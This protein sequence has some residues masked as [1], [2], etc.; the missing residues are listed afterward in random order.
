[1]RTIAIESRKGVIKWPNL[2]IA[3]GDAFRLLLQTSD[4]I[5]VWDLGDP[6]WSSTLTNGSGGM[7]KIVNAEFGPSKHELVLIHDFG[8]KVT[9]WS[10]VSGRSVEI[11]DPKT[12]VWSYEFRPNSGHLAFLS[13]PAA[14]DILTVHNT[15]SYSVMK[16]VVLQTLDAQGLKW[17]PDGKWLAIWDTP[18]TGTKIHIFT[19]DGSHYR[20]VVFGDDTKEVA[21]GVKTLC[22]NPN[23]DQ[24]AIGDF[25]QNVTILSTR[26]V[27]SCYDQ[28]YITSDLRYS[29]HQ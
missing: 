12:S 13:R 11:R 27:R 6:K 22:W 28:Q 16:S 19:A 18:S 8:S 24:L 4:D 15:E 2:K 5:R 10:L 26:T 17:S 3:T 1:L 23:S 7:G 21:L 25:N 14:Q 20:T 29:S 9:I